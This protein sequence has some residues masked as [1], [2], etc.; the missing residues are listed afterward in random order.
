MFANIFEPF[1][2]NRVNIDTKQ[3]MRPALKIQAKINLF[4]G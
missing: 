2:F 1:L 3:K 4:A